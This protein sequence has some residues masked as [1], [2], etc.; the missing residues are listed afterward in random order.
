MLSTYKEYID[1]S[2]LAPDKLSG[3]LELIRSLAKETSTITQSSYY[4]AFQTNL[5]ALTTAIEAAH[6]GDAGKGFAAVADEVRN[7]AHSSAE[8]AKA[9][10]KSLLEAKND[11]TNVGEVQD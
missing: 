7:R 2:F 9:M 1:Q 6:A 10:A 4:I 3:G 5:L 8:S 11:A